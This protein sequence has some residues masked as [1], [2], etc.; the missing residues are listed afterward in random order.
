ML[1]TIVGK[2]RRALEASHMLMSVGDFASRKS[3]I[4]IYANLGRRDRYEERVDLRLSINGRA[5]PISMRFG[6][7][8]VVGEILH[9][10]QY[11]IQTKLPDAPVVFDLGANV[12]ISLAWFFATFPRGTF[13]GFEPHPDNVSYL[14]DNFGAYDNVVIEAAGVGAA[15]GTLS[16]SEGPSAAEHVLVASDN[17]G[18]LTVP[19]VSLADY[20]EQNGIPKIDLLKID[21]EGAEIEVLRGLGDRIADVTA[22][23]GEIHE[24]MIDDRDFYALLDAAGFEVI[25]K[26]RVPGDDSVHIFEA[27]NG[28]R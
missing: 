11:A 26:T 16:L 22:M 7:I 1:Q 9:Q 12:G 13:Y 3:L 21:V 25:R 19:V 4:D 28:A 15:T 6:D 8:F 2:S 24:T 23:V 20:M 18:G 27:V 17:G 5:V 10:K 14:Q